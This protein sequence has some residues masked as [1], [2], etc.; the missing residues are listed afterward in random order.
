MEGGIQEVQSV[1]TENEPLILAQPSH[2]S[3]TSTESST[4]N[5]PFTST[6]SITSTQPST[7]QQPPA[8]GLISRPSLA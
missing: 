6:D 5:Q 8:Q 3:S 4:P 1:K 2:E 7:S